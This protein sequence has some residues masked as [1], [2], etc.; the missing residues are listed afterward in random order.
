MP[1]YFPPINS[2]N[3]ILVQ[4]PYGTS[5]EF[6]TISAPVET[7]TFWSFPL[8]G[9]GLSGYPTTPLSRFNLN[10]SNIGVNKSKDSLTF[11]GNVVMANHMFMNSDSARYLSLD[12]IPR[13]MGFTNEDPLPG[14]ITLSHTLSKQVEIHI[15][16][17]KQ[18]H[19]VNL[20]SAEYNKNGYRF[21][22]S[23]SNNDKQ[24]NITYSFAYDDVII[25]MERNDEYKQFKSVISNTFNNAIKFW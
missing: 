2:T 22:F 3:Y 4:S 19:H 24:I 1:L 5:L 17:D 15:T 14:D 18:I 8:R 21:N 11:T 16:M 25:P 12:F 6:E 20:K 7:G 23:S 10:Y 9:S 13:P